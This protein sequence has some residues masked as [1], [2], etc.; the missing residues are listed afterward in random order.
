[1]TC[2]DEASL[3]DGSAAEGLAQRSRTLLET[4]PVASQFLE[5]WP[6][7]VTTRP[8]RSRSLPV[9]RWLAEAAAQGMPTT[10]PL[11]SA[12]LEGATLLTWQQTYTAADFGPA[13]LDRYGWTELMGLRGPIPSSTVACGFLMLGPDCDYPAHAHEAEE[14]YIPL[15]GSALWMQ[16]NQGYVRRSPGLPIHHASWVPHAMRTEAEPLVAL[17]VWRG[18]ELAA[19]STIV[20]R[21]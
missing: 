7:I 2:E 16:G 8:A 20:G 3:S 13:F 11:V 12:L 1:M 6:D 10:A 9:L 18:G 17:Y 21:P 4:L 14:I 5:G 15:A 19:K